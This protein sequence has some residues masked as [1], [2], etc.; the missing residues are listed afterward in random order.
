MRLVLREYLSM[1]K[2]SGELDALLPDLLVSMGLDP[3]N[4]PQRGPRQFGVDLPAVGVDPEDGQR[5]LFLFLVKQGDIT[6]SNWDTGAQAVR[7]SLNEVFDT[8]LS[9]QVLPEHQDLTKKIVLATNG[10]M[11]QS[12]TPNWVG[13]AREHAGRHPEHGE[14]Q[15]GLWDADSLAILLEKYLL[16]EYLFPESAQKQ[17]RKTIALADQNE[18]EPRYFYALIEETLFQR[19]LPLENTPGARR[20]RACPRSTELFGKL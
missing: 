11:K 19:E 3:Q 14:I 13:Y 6:R 10:E 8:Y 2:E 9:T 16:D 4:R 17:I 12:V 7:P 1:L 18:D 15:F 5:K 20:K